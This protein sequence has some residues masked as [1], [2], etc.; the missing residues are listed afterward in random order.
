MKPLVWC[1]TGWVGNGTVDCQNAS[2]W[3]RKLLL[4]WPAFHD[5]AGKT[6]APVGTLLDIYENNILKSS[7]AAG[8]LMHVSV[9]FS[10][11]QAFGGTA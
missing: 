2:S 7:G 4:I 11:K 9:L 3:L 5:S 6:N 1:I 8:A 10:S